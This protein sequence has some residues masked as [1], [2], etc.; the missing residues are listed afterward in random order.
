MSDKTVTKEVHIEPKRKVRSVSCKNCKFWD[1]PERDSAIGI[2]RRF[3]PKI[4]R[5][6]PN[7]QGHK[8]PECYFPLSGEASYCG[9]F[10]R[11]VSKKK[12]KK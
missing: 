3:P 1:A 6:V 4:G 11:K 8:T 7:M 2:C 9:E 10:V 12:T 5:I